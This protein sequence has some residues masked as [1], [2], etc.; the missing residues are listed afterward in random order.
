MYKRQVCESVQDFCKTATIPPL[1]LTLNFCAEGNAKKHLITGWHGAETEHTWSSEP[2]SYTHLDVYKRQGCSCFLF[3]SKAEGFG[4][5][6]LE[7]FK[8]GKRVI[9]SNLPIFREILYGTT[10]CFDING[11]E[12]QQ[13]DRL[14][15]CMMSYPELPES[16]KNEI[17]ANVLKK[18]DPQILTESL[19]NFML[20]LE[21]MCIRDRRCT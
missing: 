21:E 9:T 8:Y 20:S 18:Y 1:N 16:D 11:S 15:K 17:Y 5:P 12:A 10:E 14:C 13:I 3:P 6:P 2:V 4:L 19:K 7:A